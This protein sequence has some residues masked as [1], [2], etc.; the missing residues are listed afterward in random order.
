M[1]GVS[2]E[3][4]HVHRLG[5]VVVVPAVPGHIRVP[6][7]VRALVG[8]EQPVNHRGHLS[9]GQVAVRGNFIL[10]C[11]DHHAVVYRPRQS[12]IGP[13]AIGVAVI[14]YFVAAGGVGVGSQQAGHQQHCHEKGNNSPNFSEKLDA[15]ASSFRFFEFPKLTPL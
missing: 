13:V 10:G 8:A 12:L 11:A 15:H 5:N 4:P 6:G 1:I 3:G 7:N 9:A 2:C 14:G